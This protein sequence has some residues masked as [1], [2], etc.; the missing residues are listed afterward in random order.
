MIRRR[1]P[2]CV[3]NRA[4][5][6]LYGTTD[7]LNAY[8]KKLFPTEWNGINVQCQG[9][10]CV[11]ERNGFEADFIMLAKRTPRVS[12]LAY[13]TH[14][15]G[16]LA[17]ETLHCASYTLRH[18]GIEHTQETEEAYTYYQGWLMREC[19]RHLP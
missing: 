1:L 10:W 9:H 16:V 18:A 3:Y 6:F 13:R 8:M 19:A 4:V 5:T 7:E 17:H 14:L 15:M 11:R 12:P 2:Q